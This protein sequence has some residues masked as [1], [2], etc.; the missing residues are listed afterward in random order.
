MAIEPAVSAFQQHRESLERFE[1][2]LGRARGRLAVSL[3]VLTDAIILLGQHS[4]YCRSSKDPA[5][6]TRDMR[7][8]MRS[9]E[10]AKELLASVMEELR[11]QPERT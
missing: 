5:E 11:Q 10:Q 4:V 1:F 9:I 7:L 6:P 2:Q 3:D 8:V